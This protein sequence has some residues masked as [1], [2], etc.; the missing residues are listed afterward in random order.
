MKKMGSI[1]GIYKKNVNNFD[2]INNKVDEQTKKQYQ[3]RDHDKINNIQSNFKSK[4]ALQFLETY[5]V[6]ICML[7]RRP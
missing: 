4:F 7:K 1:L 3:T 5:S 2:M 6:K